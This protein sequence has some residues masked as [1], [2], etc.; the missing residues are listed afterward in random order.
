MVQGQQYERALARLKGALDNTEVKQIQQAHTEVDAEFQPHFLPENL[1]QLSRDKLH[2]FTLLSNNQHW[3]GLQRKVKYLDHM[4]QTRDALQE[5]LD[6]SIPIEQRLN[7]LIPNWKARVPNLGKGVLTPILMV[8]YPDK[9][10]VWNGTTEGVMKELGLW[11]QFE[12]G[13]TIGERYH[14]I[15][16]TLLR[17]ANDLQVDL[18]TLDALW[19]DASKSEHDPDPTVVKETSADIDHRFRMEAYLQDFLINNWDQIELGRDWDLYEVGDDLRGYGYQFRTGVGILDLLAKHKTEPRWLVIELK[20]EESSD[21]ALGQLQRYMGWIMKHLAKAGDQVEGL[22]IA[23]DE[24]K[25]L[26]YAI[27]ATHNIKCMQYEIEF[28]L[29][30]S[31]Q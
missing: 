12:W 13:A 23:F 31:T 22:I 20:R 15:N 11:P 24:S 17:L 30:S 3:S 5:L 4:D 6:E 25:R 1:P 28:K 21:V 26:R 10:G 27:A 7:S 18:W 8:V 2:D 16:L 19:W 9:Y 29:V 14:L